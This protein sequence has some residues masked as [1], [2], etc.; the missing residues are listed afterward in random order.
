[1]K[2]SKQLSLYS[3]WIVLSAAITFGAV[4]FGFYITHKLTE[5]DLEK[6]MRSPVK[7]FYQ[8]VIDTSQKGKMS[9]D[10]AYSLVDKAFDEKFPFERFI[11]DPSKGEAP[12][13]NVFDKFALPDGR[14]MV[15][16]K[17][18][19][20]PKFLQDKHDGAP[21]PPQ[22]DRR[23]PPR[24]KPAVVTPFK[25]GTFYLSMITMLV[26]IVTGIGIS[27][28]V[29]GLYLKKKSNQLE[30]I[31]GKLKSGDL[32]ARF[33][34]SKSDEA[35]QLMIHINQMADAIEGLV[36]NL[37]KTEQSRKTLLQ[38]LAHDLRTPV[39]SMKNLQEML[40]EKGDL[41]AED[42]KRH[43]QTLALNEVLY[44]ERLVE[45]LLFLSGVND[46]KYDQNFTKLDLV[47][48]VK[49]EI[50]IFESESIQFEYSG[51]ENLIIRGNDHLLRRMLKNAFSNALRFSKKTIKV[52]LAEENGEYKLTVLDDG[53]G[54]SS[55]YLASFGEKKFS[56]QVDPMNKDYISIGLGSVIMKKI[57]DLH[58]GSLAVENQSNP[59]G[60][61]ISFKFNNLPLSF[62]I[63]L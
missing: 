44:F 22:F 50:E 20:V 40:I 8:L 9:I 14:L 30:I 1:M 57:M 60:C 48:L 55:E 19:D 62:N 34:L 24:H 56:R 11:I 17:D 27:M 28:G 38:E 26:S 41:L 59:T 47:T 52:Y 37:R 49:Q 15:F 36:E 45:D 5:D 10:E 23:R 18:H 54:M 7:T 32:K 46:P 12:K 2:L 16:Y 42:K 6:H 25:R 21:P 43:I 33:D 63:V 31:I 13:G 29:L 58:E 39:A 35:G 51:V 3:R 53:P 4:I 61:A